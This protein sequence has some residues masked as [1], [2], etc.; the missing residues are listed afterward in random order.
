MAQ[1]KILVIGDKIKSN[2]LMRYFRGKPSGPRLLDFCER[3]KIL[4]CTKSYRIE[5]ELCGYVRLLI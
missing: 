3:D 4:I 2:T 5:N 1:L